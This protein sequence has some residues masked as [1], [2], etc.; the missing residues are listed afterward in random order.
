MGK[1]PL[2]RLMTKTMDIVKG[3]RKNKKSVEMKK[4]EHLINRSFR[5]S[6]VEASSFI[7]TVSL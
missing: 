4:N 3:G 7:E 2:V 6:R 1:Q 5:I